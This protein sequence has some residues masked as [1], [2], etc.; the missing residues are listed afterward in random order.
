MQALLAIRNGVAAL[1]TQVG[2]L[3]LGIAVGLGVPVLWIWVGSQL[4]GGTAPSFTA[5]A[6]VHLGI[7]V[8]LVLIA[9]LFSF[10]VDRSNQRRR[11]LAR[12]EWMQ[13]MTEARRTDSITSTHPLELIVFFAV[14]IDIIVFL[15]WF[16]AFAN[17]GTPV[18][19]G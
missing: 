11:K 14:F 18:G 12:H 3:V 5:L 15:V 6:V 8:T 10:F 17:P 7:I 4:Q 1:C 16:F 13:G 9:A 19:Q 2:V